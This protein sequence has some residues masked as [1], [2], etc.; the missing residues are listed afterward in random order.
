MR[1]TFHLDHTR[2]AAAR[3]RD[4]DPGRDAD[5]WATL[6]DAAPDMAVPIAAADEADPHNDD[7]PE[8]AGA[9]RVHL[10]GRRRS[11]LRRS[12]G[13]AGA[14]VVLVGSIVAAGVAAG[15]PQGQPTLAGDGEG[16]STVP[17]QPPVG[18]TSP[19]SPPA[20]PPPSTDTVSPSAA[21]EPAPPSSPPATTP[22]APPDPQPPQPPP[23]DPPPPSRPAQPAEATPL[24]AGP[25]P[26]ATALDPQRAARHAEAA[27]HAD[28]ALRE[29]HAAEQGSDP[30]GTTPSAAAV[31]LQ[32]AARALDTARSLLGEDPDDHTRA[33]IAQADAALTAARTQTSRGQP[34][35]TPTSGDDPA[36][37]RGGTTHT[38]SSDNQPLARGTN[39]DLVRTAQHLLRSHG[40]TVA[41]TGQFDA[42]TDTAVRAFQT[43]HQLPTT[44][45]IDATTWAALRTTPTP[46]HQPIM[47]SPPAP[48]RALLPQQPAPPPPPTAVPPAPP[49]PAPPPDPPPPTRNYY[50]VVRGDTLSKI[51]GTTGVTVAELKQLNGLP[52]STILVGD[53]LRLN[54]QVPNKIHRTPVARAT[55]PPPPPTQPPPAPKEIHAAPTSDCAALPLPVSGA[56]FSNR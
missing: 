54:D 36:A 26:A 10:R 47:E 42:A 50:P 53:Q 41:A 6:P 13:Y 23:P 33:V 27:V 29:A 46:A 22:A 7:A 45:V 11:P 18:V 51:E 28:T 21:S 30:G 31:H 48:Q 40:A 15:T 37:D 49:P 24:P 9:A 2:P 52:S 56:C 38:P 20:S 25:P 32:T 35:T 14:G 5:P 12:V 4:P 44:G 43:A 19:P 55:T 1:R 39:G 3:E 34:D 17:T 16:T 8:S